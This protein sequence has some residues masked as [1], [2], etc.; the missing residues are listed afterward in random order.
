M[1]TTHVE[2]AVEHL[3]LEKRT[4]EALLGAHFDEEE[5]MTVQR[6]RKNE[7]LD[8]D[9]GGIGEDG[10]ARG[11]GEGNEMAEEKEEVEEDEREHEGS[12]DEEMEGSENEAMDGDDE[13]EDEDTVGHMLQADDE[14]DAVGDPILHWHSLHQDINAP[15][16]RLPP[17]ILSSDGLFDGSTEDTDLEMVLDEENTL[18]AQ[19]MLVEADQEQELWKM[20]DIS[21]SS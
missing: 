15:L 9:H 19:D 21:R 18:D 16:I 13:G 6:R 11:E 14:E 17:H 20:M 7:V 2:R 8:A 10:E 12:E 3:G 1:T 5:L 4:K